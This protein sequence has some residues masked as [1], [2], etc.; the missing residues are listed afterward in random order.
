MYR[1]ILIVVGITILFLGMSNTSFIAVDTVNIE[2]INGKS[3]CDDV[4]WWPMFRHD[5]QHS[6]FS[7]SDAPVTNNVLW[8][9][10]TGNRVHSSPAVADGKLYICCVSVYCLDANTGDYIWNYTTGESVSSSP[11]VVNGKVYIGSDDFKVYCLDG[12]TGDYIWSYKTEHE[13]ESSPA[14]ADGRV[15]IG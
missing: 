8:K 1:N 9:Y 11:A 5:P 10:K 12:N 7:T 15:Y 6:G 2:H 3:S 14:V 4:D 13:V